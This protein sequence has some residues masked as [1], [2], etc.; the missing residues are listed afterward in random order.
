[1]RIERVPASRMDQ[2]ESK[3]RKR[4]RGAGARAR[5]GRAPRDPRTRNERLVRAVLDAY[6]RRQPDEV[7]RLFSP[8]ARIHVEAP[9]EAAGDY[10]GLDG[11]VEWLRRVEAEKGPNLRITV[12]DV[13]AS[14]T[15]VVVLYDLYAGN[16]RLGRRV[17]VYHVSRNLIRDLTI[18]AGPTND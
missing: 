2:P 12:H 7:R 10:V 8:S 1:M 6:Q 9:L 13:A 4:S 17:G 14:A 5:T 3:V 18:T 16:G 11:A 15:H